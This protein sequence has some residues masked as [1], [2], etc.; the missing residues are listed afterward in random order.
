M[1]CRLLMPGSVST[2]NICGTDNDFARPSGT[3]LSASLP[4]HFVPGTVVLSLRDKNHS[5]IEAPHNDLSAY[6][7]LTPNWQQ[8]TDNWL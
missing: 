4:R 7:G 2:T 3:G 6:E 8:T 1:R 5:P